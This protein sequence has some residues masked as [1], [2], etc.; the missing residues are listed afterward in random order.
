MGLNEQN[1]DRGIETARPYAPHSSA[2]CLNE[3]NPDRGIETGAKMTCNAASRR[4]E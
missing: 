4:L 1:P 2:Y 3:Q